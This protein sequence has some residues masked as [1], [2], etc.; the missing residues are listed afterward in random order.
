MSFREAKRESPK[1]ESLAL[2]M[3]LEEF[4]PVWTDRDV[5]VGVAEVERRDPLAGTAEW[6]LV[7]PLECFGLEETV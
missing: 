4:P 1:L 3:E 5:K 6:N 7:F 2:I